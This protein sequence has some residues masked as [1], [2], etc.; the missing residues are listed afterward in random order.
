[1]D[2]AE[3]LHLA[4]TTIKRHLANTYKKMGVNSRGE[5]ARKAMAE[6]WISASDISRYDQSIFVASRT[7]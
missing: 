1:M 5:A 7:A 4:D 2:P 3:G 6:G